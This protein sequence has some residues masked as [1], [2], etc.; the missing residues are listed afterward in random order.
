MNILLFKVPFGTWQFTSGDR[1][2]QSGGS[3]P[4]AVLSPREHLS[5]YEDIFVFGCR[6]SGRGVATGI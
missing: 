3:Q 5:M 2:V 6:N 1:M 4:G